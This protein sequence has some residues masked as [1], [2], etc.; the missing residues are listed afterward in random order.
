MLNEVAQTT[1]VL[2]PPTALEER[3]REPRIRASDH[4]FLS[5]TSP[6]QPGRDRVRV[7]DVSKSGMRVCG[8][9]LIYT[10]TTVQLRLS[11]TV[12]MA[13]VRHCEPDVDGFQV[14]VQFSDVY[15]LPQREFHP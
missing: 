6:Y 1:T 7:I 11:S 12:I 10:G 15:P 9:R 14:G 4:A 2:T 3:R 8:P 13:T 5:L